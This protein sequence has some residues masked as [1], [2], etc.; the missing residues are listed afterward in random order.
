MNECASHAPCH[1]GNQAQIKPG[2]SQDMR[3]PRVAKIISKLWCN[4]YYAVA[5]NHRGK[6]IPIAGAQ[7][8]L[9]IADNG[10]ASS[11]NG[12]FEILPDNIDLRLSTGQQPD[13]FCLSR[14]GDSLSFQ[15]RGVVKIPW[16][17]AVLG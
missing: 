9:M 10:P 2:G 6:Q 7:I 5:Q 8:Y 12:S 4:L 11:A 17:I 16:I 1:A 13:T 14:A 3:E 15:V